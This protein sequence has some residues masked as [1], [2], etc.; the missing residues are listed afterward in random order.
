MSP[1]P[2]AEAQALKQQIRKAA[3][4]RRAL[5]T[6]RP[7]RSREITARLFA[8]PEFQA[9]RSLAF[10]VSIRNEVDTRPALLAALAMGKTIAVPYCQDNR[11]HLV[12]IEQESELETGTYQIPEPAADLRHRPE[13]SVEPAEL[14]LVLVPGVAFDRQGNRLGHGAGYYDRLLADVRSPALLVALA[15]DCQIVDSVPTE[16]HDVRMHRIVTESTL[17]VP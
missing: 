17:H 6:D 16:P 13:R 3:Q 2:A 5:L 1:L 12:R 9:A 15:F 8:L 14:D 11:L 4:A 10:Y 7:G